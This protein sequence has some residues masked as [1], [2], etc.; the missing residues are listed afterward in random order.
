[1]HIVYSL[2]T[3]KTTGMEGTNSFFTKEEKLVVDASGRLK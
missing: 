2:K 3:E 1:M